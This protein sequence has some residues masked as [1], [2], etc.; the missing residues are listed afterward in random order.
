MHGQQSHLVHHIYVARNFCLC[1][2]QGSYHHRHHHANTMT[3]RSTPA[4]SRSEPEAETETSMNMKVI[5]E[6]KHCGSILSDAKETR[7]T[8]RCTCI[9]MTSWRMRC[10]W[11]QEGLLPVGCCWVSFVSLA[12]TCAIA[13]FSVVCSGRSSAVLWRRLHIRKRFAFYGQR[14]VGMRQRGGSWNALSWSRGCLPL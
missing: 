10:A 1:Q 7:W 6:I 9:T 3:I 8:F 13:F 4:E 12:A 11:L 2:Q 14:R 5:P